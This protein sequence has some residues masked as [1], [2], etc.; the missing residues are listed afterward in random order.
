ME[1]VFGKSGS[2]QV[3]PGLYPTDFPLAYLRFR[4]T[5]P[6]PTAKTVESVVATASRC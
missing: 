2:V 5:P 3:F 1:I 6:E 4:T